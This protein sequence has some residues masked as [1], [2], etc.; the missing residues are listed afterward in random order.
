MYCGVVGLHSSAFTIGS[1][2]N[3]GDISGDIYFNLSDTT[4]KRRL[5]TTDENNISFQE[6][7]QKATNGNNNNF[8]SCLQVN[9]E[10]KN[11]TELNINSQENNKKKLI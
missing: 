10:I 11:K 8:E 5:E 7:E 6:N 9:G 1:V 2:G 4:S 3:S